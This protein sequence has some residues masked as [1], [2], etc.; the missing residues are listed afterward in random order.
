M[1]GDLRRLPGG[2]LSR[3]PAPPRLC[4]RAPLYAHPSSL[5]PPTSSAPA[6]PGSL[7]SQR[8][9]DPLRVGPAL[10][11]LGLSWDPGLACPLW[12]RD[13]LSPGPASPSPPGKPLVGSGSGQ[14]LS[15]GVSGARKIGGRGRGKNRYQVSGTGLSR[16]PW[17]VQEGKEVTRPHLLFCFLQA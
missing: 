7:L 15:T 6:L 1:A 17:N 14:P 12:A 2:P 8:A 13:R 11:F 5:G 4:S 10:G 3:L 16:A 9:S